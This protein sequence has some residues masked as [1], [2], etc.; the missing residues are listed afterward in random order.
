M[1]T[2]SKFEHGKTI[3]RPSTLFA[4]GGLISGG[5]AMM[6]RNV[7]IRGLRQFGSFLFVAGAGAWLGL[8]TLPMFAAADPLLCSAS[9]ERQQFDYWL[10]EWTITYPGAPSG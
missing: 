9:P 3:R 7:V 4:A 10:G 1:C 8:A 6:K 2:R 5:G